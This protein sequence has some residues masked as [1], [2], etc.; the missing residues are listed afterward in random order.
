MA[1]LCLFGFSGKFNRFVWN[2]S[3]R[4]GNERAA[5][6]G[7]GGRTI[8]G[9]ISAASSV[10]PAKEVLASAVRAKP[11]CIHH[12]CITPVITEARHFGYA[13]G[14]FRGHDLDLTLD[15]GASFPITV[16]A[17]SGYNPNV[18][19]TIATEFSTVAFRFGHSLLSSNIERA[20]N[21][22]TDIPDVSLNGA[23]ISL[24]QD[25]NVTGVDFNVAL[26]ASQF[27]RLT[28]FSQTRAG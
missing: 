9:L 5:D 18:N 16:P 3:S 10:P 19:A 28:V 11:D 7:L 6:L 25:T 21:Q 13:F 1:R 15:G 4:G 24:A 27:G 26:S 22:G 2:S 14:Q 8:S 17:Y 12:R 23:A 20:T